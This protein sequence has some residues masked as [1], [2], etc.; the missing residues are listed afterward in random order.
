MAEDSFFDGGKNSYEN[1]NAD[2][3]PDK[4]LKYKKILLLVVGV[5]IFVLVVL[6]ILTVNGAST[7]KDTTAPTIY[8]NG[9]KT[10][11]LLVGDVF[12]DP[13]IRATDVND[14]DV[15]DKT[16]ITGTV[17]TN[18]EGTYKITYKVRDKEGNEAVVTR[19]VVVQSKEA[20]AIS[21]SPNGSDTIAE[22]YSVTVTIKA[23]ENTTITTAKYQWTVT[24]DEPVASGF[25]SDIT[26]PISSPAKVTGNY[27]LWVYA[28]ESSGI[29]RVVSSNVFKIGKVDTTVKD[30]VAPVVSFSPSGDKNVAESHSTTVSVTDDNSGVDIIRYLWS[31]RAD[32]HL[33]D[34]IKYTLKNNSSE[35]TPKGETGDYYLWVYATD[36][37]GNEVIARSEAFT[38][39]APEGNN[40]PIVE[41]KINPTCKTSG[42]SNSWYRANRTIIITCS[43]TG[44]SGVSTCNGTSGEKVTINYS[45]D[46]N[47]TY[48]YTVKDKSNN[49]GSC[50]AQ[51]K[52]D[53]TPPT[54]SLTPNS[55]SVAAPSFSPAL[56]VKDSGSGIKIVKYKWSTDAKTAPSFT[57][58]TVSKIALLSKSIPTPTI[59]TH[60]ESYYLWVYA[61]DNIGNT[62]TKQSGEFKLI[63]NTIVDRTAP[64]V[65]ITPDPTAG[66]YKTSHYAT[67]SAS[68][69]VNGSGIGTLKYKWAT[70]QPTASSFTSTF[71]SGSK[72]TS[73][74]SI[75]GSYYLWILA[76]DKA[77]NQVITNKS[78][79]VTSATVFKIDNLAPAAKITFVKKGTTTS[80]APS[81]SSSIRK[82]VAYDSTIKIES[83]NDPQSGIRQV[84][85]SYI[86]GSST[87][88]AI[89]FGVPIIRNITVTGN[90]DISISMTD[91]LG[92]VNKIN[93]YIGIDKTPPT[94]PSI[95]LG[96]SAGTA[97]VTCGKDSI[98]GIPRNCIKYRI[99]TETYSISNLTSSTTSGKTLTISGTQYL[100]AATIDNAS[101]ASGVICKL[102]GKK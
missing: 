30:T 60:A 72:I 95:T 66:T 33:A 94:N 56:S 69:G 76:I 17:D 38:I 97:T 24:P 57:D 99:G 44:G 102:V 48:T 23:P 84:L 52:I 79:N 29:S 18:K 27:Y 93:Y 85:Y 13:G 65:T 55:G 80:F 31:K 101:N 28:V 8:L 12:T 15:T 9:N 89:S 58:A 14:G 16:M 75:A 2:S 35:T 91:N 59:T 86:A 68:D 70:S 25:T 6:S 7:A 100:C 40:P 98:S 92:N 11:N 42:G 77:G 87:D 71:T 73:P 50:T 20:P 82:W 1:S 37:A 19:T 22:S 88:S 45:A 4:G 62:Y 34:S 26:T 78:F 32:S 47:K 53:K 46:T 43:D 54:M 96:S 41:D 63:P 74:A 51:V 81:T 67:V 3:D 39:K 61:E 21:F 49:Q 36:K 64:S 5:V 10:I 83:I 90:I